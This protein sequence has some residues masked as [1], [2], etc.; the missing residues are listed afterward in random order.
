MGLLYFTL[1]YVRPA[2]GAAYVQRPGG[3]RPAA[4]AAY[5]QRSGVRSA[6][7]AAYVQRPGRRTSSGRG[8]V[9]PAAGTFKNNGRNFGVT[10]P[11]HNLEIVTTAS[12]I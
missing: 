1:L 6:A 2:A 7:G 5:V 10:V 8:G 11:T 9:R 4:G 3:V 12:T